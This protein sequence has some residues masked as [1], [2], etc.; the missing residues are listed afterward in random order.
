MKNPNRKAGGK[1]REHGLDIG[2]LKLCLVLVLAGYFIAFLVLLGE[3]A[4]QWYRSGKA[5]VM[6][7]ALMRKVSSVSGLSSLTSSAKAS[8]TSANP[9]VVIT[10]TEDLESFAADSLQS[11][12]LE[13]EHRLSGC[14]AED[15]DTVAN[16]LGDIKAV[17]C[18]QIKEL[19]LV[20]Y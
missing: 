13:M 6:G 15:C 4:L 19:E 9:S 16:S 12:P 11:L 1:R 8:D 20:K 17:S 14:V 5:T 10:D 18:P 2:D 7:I 3:H